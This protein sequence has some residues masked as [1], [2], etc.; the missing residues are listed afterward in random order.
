MSSIRTL[1]L[2][3]Y[4]FRNNIHLQSQTQRTPPQVFTPLETTFNSK[5]RLKEHFLLVSLLWFYPISLFHIPPKRLATLLP[6]KCHSFHTYYGIW[7]NLDILQLAIYIL[8]IVC[9][10]MKC[11]PKANNMCAI[12]YSSFIVLFIYK[13]KDRGCI[14]FLFCISR[15]DSIQTFNNGGNNNTALSNTLV[16]YL[17]LLQK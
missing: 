13:D 7:H 10:K 14:N 3:V 16:I 6:L 11:G 2:S 15:S 8:K 12:H 17:H 9:Q 1:F 5:A 4:A